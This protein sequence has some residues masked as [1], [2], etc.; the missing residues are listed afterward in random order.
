V[1]FAFFLAVS[2]AVLALLV[3]PAQATLELGV[4]VPGSIVAVD[5]VDSFDIGLQAG[6]TI[7][8]QCTRTSGTLL[9][10]VELTNI[11][12]SVSIGVYGTPSP[13]LDY[14]VPTGGAYTITVRDGLTGASTGDYV[15]CVQILNRPQNEQTLTMGQAVTGPALAPGAFATFTF[16]SQS[17]DAYFIRCGRAA[18][19]VSPRY[20]LMDPSGTMIA[21][22]STSS[23]TFLDQ[24]C[25]LPTPGRYT[26]IVGDTHS[27]PEAG[28]LG[29]FAQR[30]NRPDGAVQVKVG[31]TMPCTNS[32][33]VKL[34]TFR[35]TIEKGD[36]IAAWVTRT[37]GSFAP[38]I[39]L[40]DPA[41]ALLATGASSSGIDLSRTLS[42]SGSYTLLVGDSITSTNTGQ[43]NLYVQKPAHPGNA[44]F[45]PEGVTVSGAIASPGDMKTFI[46]TA[47][48]GRS[49]EV[50][51]YHSRT[52]GTLYPHLH[53]YDVYGIELMRWYTQG[54]TLWDSFTAKPGMSYIA[55]VGSG[56]NGLGTGEY[57]FKWDLALAYEMSALVAA[58]GLVNLDPNDMPRL[59]RLQPFGI[60]NLVDATALLR[61]AWGK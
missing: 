24:Q 9:P 5:E 57:T 4:P 21:Y 50:T 48:Q 22:D 26:L 45:V 56:G 43:Y 20:L 2:C 35:L 25:T 28:T 8:I 41:G 44:V 19:T 32:S 52:T 53:L 36:T 37:Y 27:P 3:L 34:D 58:G 11:W 14:T 17:G 31:E 6:D 33:P 15:L 40:F 51:I 54:V 29:V 12:H 13:I 60:V 18:G 7:V 16:S 10:Y 47:P 1:K 38:R 55:V 49:G 61:K 42:A 46:F 30:T 23:G 59:D 39:M